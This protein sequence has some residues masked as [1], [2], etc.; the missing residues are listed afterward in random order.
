MTPKIDSI[1]VL[2]LLNYQNINENM[3]HPPIQVDLCQKNDNL[4]Y[5]FFYKTIFINLKRIIA[6]NRSNASQRV[7]QY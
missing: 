4:F 3:Q 6:N 2:N 7:M 1:N 5:Y